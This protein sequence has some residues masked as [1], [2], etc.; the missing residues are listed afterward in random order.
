V[1]ELEF[2]PNSSAELDQLLLRDAREYRD[3]RDIKRRRTSCVMVP[4]SPAE[5][6]QMLLT[7]VRN[8]DVYMKYHEWRRAGFSDMFRVYLESQVCYEDGPRRHLPYIFI[9]AVG[10]LSNTPIT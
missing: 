2:G 6:G 1:C 7:A 5:L 9:A 3:M 4:R 10:P 8:K